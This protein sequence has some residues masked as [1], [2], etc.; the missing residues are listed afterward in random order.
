MDR[1][2]AFKLDEYV[3]AK[4]ISLLLIGGLGVHIPGVGRGKWEV[5]RGKGEVGRGK[6][7]GGREYLFTFT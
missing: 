7:E 2:A 1:R 6:W 5:G 3:G 4:Y